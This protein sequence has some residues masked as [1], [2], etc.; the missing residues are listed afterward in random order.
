METTQGI[1]LYSFVYLKLAKAPC[2][3]YYLLCFSFNKIRQ[4]SG[5]SSAWRRDW[6]DGGRKVAQI[7][8]THISKCKNNK[9]KFEKR[10]MTVKTLCLTL[11]KISPR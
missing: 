3:S 8:Y 5:T 9:I 10:K 7:M 2:F 6:G 1:S 4:E 11:N